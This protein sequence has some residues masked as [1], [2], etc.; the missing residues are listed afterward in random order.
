MIGR[1]PVGPLAAGRAPHGIKSIVEIFKTRGDKLQISCLIGGS[2]VAK[3]NEA[4][5]SAL[6]D[7]SVQQSMAESNSSKVGHRVWMYVCSMH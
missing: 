1:L 2:R 5:G 4:P 7:E 6:P 3:E